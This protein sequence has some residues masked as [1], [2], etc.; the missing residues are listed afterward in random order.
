METLLARLSIKTGMGRFEFGGAHLYSST[1]EL[2]QEDGK[3]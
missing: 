2:R 1:R 3:F